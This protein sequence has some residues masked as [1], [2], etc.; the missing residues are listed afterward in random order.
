MKAELPLVRPDVVEGIGEIPDMSVW[1]LGGE[2]TEKR[3]RLQPH[4]EA[5]AAP[6][7]VAMEAT[8]IDERRGEL[9]EEL[10]R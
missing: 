1:L 10:G 5:F 6:T 4:G 2:P 9:P 3:D 7:E 8:Q